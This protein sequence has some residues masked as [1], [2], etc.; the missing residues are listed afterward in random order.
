MP[1]ITNSDLFELFTGKRGTVHI[2]TRND[3]DI[4]G[5]CERRYDPE[6]KEK[7]AIS[8]SIK[9]SDFDDIQNTFSGISWSFPLLTDY[10]L[11]MLWIREAKFGMNPSLKTGDIFTFVNNA[12]NLSTTD[13][14]VEAAAIKTLMELALDALL[15]RKHLRVECEDHLKPG[16]TIQRNRGEIHRVFIYSL[17]LAGKKRAEKIFE[18][19]EEYIYDHTD[20]SPETY[21]EWKPYVMGA[22]DVI[23]IE[24]IDFVEQKPKSHANSKQS[25][26][27]T[28][29]H[30]NKL[31]GSGKL[32]KKRTSKYEDAVKGYLDD[33]AV[34]VKEEP[35]GFICA[36]VMNLSAQD[37]AEHLKRRDERFANPTIDSIKDRIRR[38]E[39]WKNRKETLKEFYNTRTF[40]NPLSINEPLPHGMSVVNNRRKD[41]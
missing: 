23:L 29:K 8:R 4:I 31:C 11:W 38:T 37:I 25:P 6:A 9:K 28:S 35:N 16:N 40:N 17:T 3:G 21:E 18:K 33:L 41:E 5:F 24:E 32:R 15:K 7:K 12:Y 14:P 20:D 19:P 27:S 30:E 36:K 1:K 13:V 10:I 34:Q 2:K 22:P 26:Q 39:A